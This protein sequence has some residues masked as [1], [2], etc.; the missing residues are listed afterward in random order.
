MI[1]KQL[2]TNIFN[3]TLESMPQSVVLHAKKSLLNWLGVTIGGINHE[4]INILLETTEELTNSDQ[5]TIL[6]RNKKMDI[7]SATLINGT[8][9]HIFDYD[10]THLDTI[11]H[12][13]GP[14]APVVFALGEKFGTDCQTLLRAFILGCEVELR[15]SKAI[16]PSHYQNG[17]HITS[18][19][20]VFGAMTAAGIIMEV[21]EEK[22]A[23][24]LGL[25]GTQAFGL[26][27]M[28]GTMT[29]SFHPGKAAQNGLL[30]ALLVKN[31]FTSSDQVLEAKRGF[32]NVYNSNSQP[33]KILENWGEDWQ[34]EKNS[35]KPY[36]CGI[37]L[38]PSIDACIK[39]SNVIT[40]NEVKE[41]QLTVHP[42]VLE[43]TGKKFPATGLEAKFSIYHA[44]AIS[45]LEQDA[46]EEQFSDNK[47]QNPEVVAFRKKIKPFVNDS[48][49][50]EKV[51][52]NLIK[53][54]GT[55]YDIYVEH[56][57]GSLEKPMTQENINRKFTNLCKD[58]L[59]ERR[60]K[61]LIDRMMEFENLA[62]IQEVLKY[63]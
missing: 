27:E 13:S 54:D 24:G 41:I 8:S 61:L 48:M 53:Q 4:T 9:S 2:A 46:S 31:G 22:M 11:H 18:S 59:P 63:I 35:F 29:K 62:S 47:V 15:I 33:E 7:L 17:F 25:A 14:V 28:F 37:V 10:D 30:A 51:S 56:A 19:T 1:T 3:T 23:M 12:P 39:L 5:A 26:R 52:A 43:L 42:Y 45:F 34:L 57:T 38:H 60:I 6:G 36:A 20:G 58:N 21:N 50:K 49:D 55:E 16:Y 32:L 44:S 40:P